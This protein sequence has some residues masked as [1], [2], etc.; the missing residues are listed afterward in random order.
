MIKHAQLSDN[1]I[2][3]LKPKE[4]EYKIGD[5]N[6][7]WL[8][9]TPNG[10]KLWRFRYTLNGKG[11]TKSLGKYPAL[12]LK[13]ARL[14]RDEYQKQLS[15]G[16]K[17]RDTTSGKTFKEISEEY[18]ERRSDLSDRYMKDIRALLERDF[19]PSIK[20]KIL[21]DITVSHF[22]D[23]FEKMEKRGIKTATKKAGSLV[24]RIL[25]YAVAKQYTT[26]NPMATIDLSSLLEKHT[27]NNFAHITDVEQ[28]KQLLQAIDGYEGDIYTRT[29]LM[30]MPYAFVR[31]ANIRGML[32]SELDLKAKTW[33]IPAEKMKIP[34]DHVVPL[35]DSMIEILNN[36]KENN[37]EFVFPSPQSTKRQLSNNT[38][39]VALK[40]LGF[41]DKMTSHG[42]RHTAS[43][44]L[45][46]NIHKHGVQSEVIEMQLAHVE[47]N[48]VKGVYNK[49]LYI[50]ER[51][52]LMEWWSDFVDTLKKP[53]Q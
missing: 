2:K 9:V 11:S 3:A 30:F 42:F 40:R 47:K 52:R 32:W 18:L 22:I 43:T 7:L 51:V 13:E 21:D 6:G 34:R 5:G 16:M 45:H 10:S 15:T 23:I 27:P 1:K 31:P 50:P 53:D 39:N 26:N 44:M 29:A 20:N 4:K 14:K 38:L 24:N 46:E 17:P 49:A 41:K 12:S 19:Y 37:S 35:T 36:V 25:M 48:S 28:F 33:I 8:F